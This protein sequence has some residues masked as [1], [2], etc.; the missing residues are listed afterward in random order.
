MS[1]LADYQNL[2]KRTRQEREL[3]SKY[4]AESTLKTLIPSF[5]NFYYAWKSHGKE[6][7][8]EK[9]IETLGKFIESMQ[10][11]HLNMFKS[12]EAIGI[13]MITPNIEDSFDPS[14][15]EAIVQIP[16]DQKEG[17]IVEILSPGYML[18]DKIIKVCQVAIAS[19]IPTITTE[20]TE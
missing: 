18:H 1:S 12:L 14:L 7:Q 6:E 16:S 15:H 4:M 9:N 11:L 19:A 5:D 8:T 20:E 13:K 3:M 10:M 17:S 2:H